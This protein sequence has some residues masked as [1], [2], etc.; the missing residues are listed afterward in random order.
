MWICLEVVL[1]GWFHSLFSGYNSQV[2]WCQDT[3]HKSA[4]VAWSSRNSQA[5][6]ELEQVRGS[7]QNQPNNQGFS[8]L[9]L[10]VKWG[11]AKTRH[12]TIASFASIRSL[13]IESYLY[14]LQTSHVLLQVLPQQYTMWVCIIWHIQKFLLQEISVVFPLVQEII[15][16]K[17]RNYYRKAPLVKIEKLWSRIVSS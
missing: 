7:N 10:S 6:T 8:A 17:D 15:F 9:P 3:K 16:A 4:A 13:S 1:W 5:S 12:K 2:E 14:S 11:T